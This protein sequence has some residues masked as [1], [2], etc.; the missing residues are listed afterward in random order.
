MRAAPSDCSPRRVPVAVRCVPSCSARASSSAGWA[1]SWASSSARCAGTA[2]VLVATSRFERFLLAP[3]V[4]PLELLALTLVGVVRA[5]S[6]PS[7]PRAGCP[8]G[9]GRGPER[10]R[11]VVRTR[12]RFPVVGLV[13]AAVGTALALGGGA[14][15]LAVQ[16]QET[17]SSRLLGVVA[18]MILAGAVLTQRGL[19][20]ATPAVVGAAARLGRRLPLAP[21]LA[22]RDAARH[23]GRTAPAVA[24]VLA[25]MAGWV[26]LTLFVASMSDKDE[27]GYQRPRL[28]PGPAAQQLRHRPGLA[29]GAAG[30]GQPR[31]TAGPRGAASGF[32]S[33]LAARPRA[34]PSPSSRRPRT[35]AHS[36]SSA[37]RA[38]ARPGGLAAAAQDERCNRQATFINTPFSGP[39]VGD[40]DAGVGW[41]VSRR[42]RR[43]RPSTPAEWSCSTPP[44]CS[45]GAPPSRCRRTTRPAA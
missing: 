9:R 6:R 4:R 42:R 44:T 8:A 40:Y 3:D 11:G 38:R 2:T 45:T 34:R 25:A 14:L 13:T 37:P 24:A 23:R 28:R 18:V 20:V 29:G 15:A 10:S 32:P 17:P 31:V 12:R 16:R 33:T 36:T 21:R 35:A 22:L 30:S 19:I 26:A 1:V 7:C 43:G 39:L 27:R 5:S 41:S